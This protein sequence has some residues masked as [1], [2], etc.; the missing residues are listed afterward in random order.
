MSKEFE[1]EIFAPS[2]ASHFAGDGRLSG[3]ARK[4]LWAMRRMTAMFS[5]ALSLRVRASS[6]SKT[7]S[8]G[9]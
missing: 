6:S 9:Q 8:R 5:G 7:T 1:E 3:W 4:M 2:C